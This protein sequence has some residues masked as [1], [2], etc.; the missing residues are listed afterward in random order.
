MVHCQGD[1][2]EGRRVLLDVDGYEESRKG[3]GTGSREDRAASVEPP[4]RSGGQSQPTT[5][6]PSKARTHN[7]GE[8][9]R[10]FIHER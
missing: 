4:M 3:E 7:V 2:K 8:R 10:A 1:Y 9:G 6:N 5:T